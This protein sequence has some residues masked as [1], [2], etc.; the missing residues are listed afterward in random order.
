MKPED[1]EDLTQAFFEKLLAREFFQK[2]QKDGGR[3]RSLLLTSMK[4]FA[5]DEWR[6]GVAQKRGSDR[7]VEIDGLSAEERL[8]AEAQDQVG[9]DLEFDRCWAREILRQAMEKLE[10]AYD[11]SGKAKVFGALKNQLVSGQD[12]S[13]QEIAEELGLAESTA[14][15]LAFKL[16]RRYRR[17]IE[18]AVA[19]TVTTAEQAADELAYLQSLFSSPA[20]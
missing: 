19:D 2:V 11:D 12:R 13:Y 8:K 4:H 1:A 14:R 3:L 9:P 16:R 18:E 20:S 10:A 6:R 17:F 5:T 15:V 7:V